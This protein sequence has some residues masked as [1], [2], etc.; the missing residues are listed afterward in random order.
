MHSKQWPFFAFWLLYCRSTTKFKCTK[1]GWKISCL[2]CLVQKQRFCIQ[3]DTFIFMFT[4][5]DVQIHINTYK[6]SWQRDTNACQ[7]HSI[8]QRQCTHRKMVN[9]ALKPIWF[10]AYARPTLRMKRCYVYVNCLQWH[11]LFSSLFSKAFSKF[12]N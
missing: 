7:H 8:V 2:V 1:A 10:K 3:N 4:Y 5:S 6:K 9:I 12:S 11:R